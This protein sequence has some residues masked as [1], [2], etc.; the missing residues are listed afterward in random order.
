MT[1]TNH[2]PGTASFAGPKLLKARHPW[3]LVSAFGVLAVLVALAMSLATNANMQWSVVGEY[4]FRRQILLGLA[5]TIIMTTLCM[6]MGTILGIFL[7]IMRMS[8]NPVLNL[9]AQAYIW[10]FRGVPLLVQLVFWF[11]LALLWP[12][13]GVVV[14]LIG[15]DWSVSTNA[16][17]SSF[18]ASVLGLALHE[19]AYMAEVVRAGILGVD[20][21]QGEAGRSLGMTEG[22]LMR[23]VVLP[24]AMRIII[25]P[26]GNQLI[27][28]LKATSLV[29]FIA[30]GELMTAVHNV[31]SHNFKVIPLLIVATIWYLSVTTIATIIQYFIEKRFGQGF[32]EPGNRKIKIDQEAAA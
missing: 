7:A 17:I 16:L 22:Q 26:T 30:G 32:G 3:R 25:P 8:G 28:L 21:G 11:N 24:Q 6:V 13:I 31:Y 15:V 4:L 2:I 20:R 1:A 27:S 9:S 18:V 29:A 10:F 23:R 14:P 12:R 5:N 19:A